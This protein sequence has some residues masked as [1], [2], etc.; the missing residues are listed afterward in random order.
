MLL[1]AGG[2]IHIGRKTNWSLIQT[3]TNDIT[4]KTFPPLYRLLRGRKSPALCELGELELATVQQK[5]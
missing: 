1:A 5:T 3:E 2:R 4:K